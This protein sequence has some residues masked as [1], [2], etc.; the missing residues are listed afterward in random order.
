M[1][2]RFCCVLD[3]KPSVVTSP[4]GASP[5]QPES[6]DTSAAQAERARLEAGWRS[7]LLRVIESFSTDN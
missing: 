4:G 7:D 6:P 1:K 3:K 5:L 2:R